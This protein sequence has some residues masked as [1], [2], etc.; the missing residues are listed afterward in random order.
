M[1]IERN[2]KGQFIKGHRSI[3][4]WLGKKRLSPSIKTRE[5]LSDANKGKIR[6]IEMKKRYSESKLDKKNPSF[7]KKGKNAFHWTGGTAKRQLSS[8]QYRRWRLSVFV[9]DNFTCINCNQVGGDLEAH[10]I[11]FWAKYPKLRFN[12][13]N[14]ATLCKRC[15]NLTK[16]YVNI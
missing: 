12:I 5:K 7:G 16:K 11:K 1:K 13:N 9:R 4:Y 6:S 2:K 8:P 14:G 3:K 15:H 10:H